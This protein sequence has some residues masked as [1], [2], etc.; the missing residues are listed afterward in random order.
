M[1]DNLALEIPMQF[2]AEQHLAAAKS[3]REKAESLAELERVRA[4]HVSNALLTLAVLAAKSRGG[5]SLSAFDREALCPDWTI[6]DEQVRRLAPVPDQ[7]QRLSQ[8]RQLTEQG[9][10]G[11]EMDTFEE[12]SAPHRFPLSVDDISQVKKVV[13]FVREQLPTMN[14]AHVRS[15]AT[16]LLAL[17]RLPAATPGIQVTFGFV[18]RNIDG[19]YGWADIAIQDIGERKVWQI[20]G[21]PEADA[22]KG[23]ISITS[24]L[25]RALIGKRTGANAKVATPA[26]IKAYRIEKVEWR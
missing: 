15:A 4:I 10:E 17:E 7:D 23:T 13:E 14:P 22:K 20:V 6:I 25:A 26:G 19:N 9:R 16:V 21:E 1:G 8:A 12:T 18:Q 5:I 2:S 11:T 24:P 3:H